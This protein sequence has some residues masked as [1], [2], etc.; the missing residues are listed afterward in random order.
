MTHAV[1]SCMKGG[2]IFM[3]D[4]TDE[5]PQEF[6]APPRKSGMMLR[7]ETPIV[8]RNSISG[9]ALIAVVAIMTFLASLTIG[10]VLL[11]D[12]AAGEW[13][14]EVSREVTIQ[15]R[16]AAGRDVEADVQRATALARGIT[17]ISDVRAM[18]KDESTKLLEPWLGASLAVGDLPVPRMIVLSVASGGADLAQLRSVLTREVPSA[19][20]D[21]HRGWV[22]R[23]RTMARSAVAGGIVILLLMV[24]ATILSVSFATRGAMATNRAVIEVLHFVGARNGYIAGHFQKHFLVLGLQGGALGG[25]AAVLLFLVAGLL[26]RLFGGS[27]PSDQAAALFGTF[28]LG[29][30]GYLAVLAQVVLIALVTA[31]TSRQTVNRTLEAID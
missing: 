9:R 6:T 27:A 15:V 20:L 1:W 22:E 8:P 19:A 3:T 23:M 10:A 31:F 18:S 25:G 24:A 21:D 12:R 28:S 17:G 16:P 4:M 2:F 26:S 7:F 14:A 5:K 30:A 11:I 29:L 13:Q